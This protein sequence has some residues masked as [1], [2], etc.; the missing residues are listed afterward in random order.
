MDAEKERLPADLPNPFTTAQALLHGIP[1]VTLHRLAT[2]GE[3]SAIARGLYRRRTDGVF[4][5][6]LAEIAAKI[7]TATI[8]LTSA[9]VEHGLS[10]AIPARI[11]IAIPRGAW[12]PKT[13]APIT[14]HRF[15]L[16]TFEWERD[17]RPIPGTNM[18]IGIYSAERTLADLA[19]HPNKDQTELVEGIRRWMRRHGNHPAKLLKIAKKLPGAEIQI[20]RIMEILV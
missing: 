19:R 3:I 4:D 18:T 15:D 11:D 20:Q 7:P 17:K 9:L 8:C 12:A 2:R 16:R 10:D 5:F 6:D 13:G 1:R 14:W